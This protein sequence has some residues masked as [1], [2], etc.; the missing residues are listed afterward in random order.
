MATG[1]VSSCLQNLPLEILYL[2][3]EGLSFESLLKLSCV[4]KRMRNVAIPR[5]F[6]NYTIIFSEE[7]F[8]KLK[9]FCEST[10]CE[11]VVSLKY[12]VADLIEPEVID[13]NYY[14]TEVLTP[15][16]YVAREESA[17][18]EGLETSSYLT[19]YN[20]YHLRCIEEGEIITSETDLTTLSVALGVMPKLSEL[21]I[22]FEDDEMGEDWIKGYQNS[23][24]TRG[25]D[26]LEHHL[27]TV[28]KAIHSAKNSGLSL[29]TAWLSCRLKDPWMLDALTDLV[30]TDG[31]KDLMEIL[32]RNVETLGLEGTEVWSI[33]LPD[34]MPP[35]RQLHLRRLGSCFCCIERLIDNGEIGSLRLQNV[36][37]I[38]NGKLV[39]ISPGLISERLRVPTSSVLE[40]SNHCCNPN[41]IGNE[42]KDFTVLLDKREPKESDSDEEEHRDASIEL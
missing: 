26:S 40:T 21:V 34:E 20:Y 29:K 16:E 39:T 9:G 27:R 18:A 38:M 36:R 31:F 17:E 6:R 24:L 35:L 30:D 19:L 15:D 7:G 8:N 12:I 11:N 4:N 25:V 2:I 23:M 28:T 5:I 37:A 13:Y 14:K 10:L 41:C 32:I 33:I 1:A 42:L 3:A 22:S